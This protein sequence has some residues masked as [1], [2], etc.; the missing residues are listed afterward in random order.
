[1]AG[2][3]QFDQ[4][5]VLDCAMAVFWERGYEAT[6]IQ[7][8]V[9][10]T[11]LNRG[12]LYATFRDKKQLFLAVLA[13]YANRVGNPL[14][15]ELAD[16][17]PRQAIERMFAAILRRTS[18]STQ[19]RGCLITNTALECPRSGDD[20]SRTIAAWVGQQ[21]SALYHVLLHAQATGA[22][23]RTRDCRALARFF[24]G[25]AQGLN[26][27]HKAMADPAVLQ[28]M[29]RVA[30][31]VWDAPQAPPPG[32]RSRQK[33]KRMRQPRHERTS[34]TRPHNQRQ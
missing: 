1:M 31:Q 29:V 9:E 19:P 4:E 16:P 14:M 24:V 13:H 25:V 27:V 21:E 11:G 20:I 3:K 10:A 2:V 34:S 18:D 15:A 6:S 8:V 33:R 26:V 22:L 28:D 5:E 23:P 12:S 7:D 30:M 32:D 17:D